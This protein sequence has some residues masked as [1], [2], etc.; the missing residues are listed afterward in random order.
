MNPKTL[1]PLLTP[2]LL[3]TFLILLL[4][5]A[6][7]AEAQIK[8][9]FRVVPEALWQDRSQNRE[10]TLPSG[11]VF[12][13]RA[14]SYS[15]EIVATV[16]EPSLVTPGQWLWISE[17]ED[18]QGGLYVSVVSGR[19]HYPEGAEPYDKGLV[20]PV[21]PACKVDVGPATEWQGVT[22][23]DAVSLDR[24]A[25]Y[26]VVVRERR[27]FHVPE[28][29]FLVYTVDEEGVTAISPVQTC[30]A[31]ETVRLSRPTPPTADAQNVMVSV[32]IPEGMEG[33][34]EQ[35][36]VLL[37]PTRDASRPLPPQPP[38]AALL[39]N[40]R[41]TFFFLDVEAR[42]PLELQVRHPKAQSH[43]QELSPLPGGVRE[44]PDVVLEDAP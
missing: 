37:A 13:Y 2:R 14:G 21:V 26:P 23:L 4:L 16:N 42:E 39:T 19:I 12:L 33:D 31:G 8:I 17:A 34:T 29:R 24:N 40:Y 41:A 20:G 5:P 32:Q 15:P 25:V 1:L 11:K 6:P 28:G 38:T 9:T 36:S 30:G 7:A 22:R 27:S 3:L 44:L 18:G 10:H 43:R 35:I